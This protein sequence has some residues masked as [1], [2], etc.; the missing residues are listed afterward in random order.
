MHESKLEGF[1]KEAF[2]AEATPAINFLKKGFSPLSELYVFAVFLYASRYRQPLAKALLACQAEW[3][4]VWG[5][6]HVDLRADPDAPCDAGVQNRVSFA[7]I[8]K[9]LGIPNPHEKG[10]NVP[11]GAFRVTTRNSAFQF[12]PLDN[13]GQRTITKEGEG[14]EPNFSQCEVIFAGEGT[15]MMCLA[16][17]P[18]AGCFIT[19]RVESI[20]PE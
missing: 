4:R 10:N 13:D 14:K 7:N 3:D 11:K 9:H 6:Q 2:G 5:Q 8:Y 20:T 17:E 18:I 1:L 15:A 16:L 19:S 12:G